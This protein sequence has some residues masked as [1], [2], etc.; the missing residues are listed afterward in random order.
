[1]VEYFPSLSKEYVLEE[2]SRIYKEIFH[3]IPSQEEIILV[4]KEKL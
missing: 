3:E 4:V 2:A 1:L